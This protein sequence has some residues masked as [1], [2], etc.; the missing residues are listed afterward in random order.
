MRILMLWGKVGCWHVQFKL[1]RRAFSD[2]LANSAR[3]HFSRKNVFFPRFCLGLTQEASP[4]LK[5]LL[6]LVLCSFYS[7]TC[8]RRKQF[9]KIIAFFVSVLKFFEQQVIVW[10]RIFVEQP[11]LRAKRVVFRIVGSRSVLMAQVLFL[12]V[13]SLPAVGSNHT[14]I[15]KTDGIMFARL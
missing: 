4:W 3:L 6:S 1:V 10:Y 2:L 9:S 14:S 7:Y 12:T 8:K 13:L 11:S 5:F 15:I